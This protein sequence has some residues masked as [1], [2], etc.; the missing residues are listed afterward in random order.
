MHD[1]TS[2]RY[3]FALHSVE[4]LYIRTSQEHCRCHKVWVKETKSN[5]IEDTVFLKHKYLRNMT[6]TTDNTMF[7]ADDDLAS[8]LYN[9]TPKKFE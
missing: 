8:E 6:I 3:K 1:K 5:R 7:Q 9:N 4:V 2:Q